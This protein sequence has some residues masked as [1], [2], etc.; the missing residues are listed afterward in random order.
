METTIEQYRTLKDNSICKYCR[1]F[2]KIEKCPFVCECSG[3]CNE[4]C[5]V[6][7]CFGCYKY[8]NQ[9]YCCNCKEYHKSSICPKED[10]SIYQTDLFQLK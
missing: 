10:I 7:K 2:H 4:T 9:N 3:K 6:Q 5:L 8:H 1:T